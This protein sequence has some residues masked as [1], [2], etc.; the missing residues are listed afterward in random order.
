MRRYRRITILTCT[1]CLSMSYLLSFFLVRK[2]VIL[3]YLSID[4]NIRGRHVL[5]HYFSGNQNVNS[6]M[7]YFYYPIHM[8][9]GDNESLLDVLE[10]DRY[11][12]PHRPL[13]VRNMDKLIL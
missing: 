6:L 13:Y 10:S 5:A 2:T 1:V 7:Y 12:R 11:F 3:D 8:S 4:S 9:L